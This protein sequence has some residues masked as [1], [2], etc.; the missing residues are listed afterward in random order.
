MHIMIMGSRT[1]KNTGV[2]GEEERIDRQ[3]CRPSAELH[4]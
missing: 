3:I 4:D 1:D 2:E